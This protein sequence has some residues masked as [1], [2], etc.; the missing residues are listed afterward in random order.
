MKIALSQRVFYHKGRAYDAIEHA[1][2]SYLDNHTL[3]FVPNTLEQNFQQLAQELDAFIIT[4]GDD[5]AIRRT[6][7]LK[8][9]SAMMAEQKPVVGICHGCFLLT[10]VLGGTVVEVD[11]HV[12]TEH[13][14]VYFGKQ[15]RVNSYHSL[16]IDKLHDSAKIL[17]TDLEGHTEAW[18]DGNLA[19]IVWHPERM[20][21]PWI[22][23]EI[24]NLLKV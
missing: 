21:K 3:Y 10:D 22:P 13:D 12:D 18:I 11:D 19:G 6:T 23:S 17:A 4:G 5:S 20:L 7:E 14:V 16:A 2:Y 1:W 24:Q 9:A 8:L 15:Y